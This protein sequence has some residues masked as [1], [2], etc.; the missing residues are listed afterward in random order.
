M[1]KLKII[2]VIFLLF[3]YIFVSLNIVLASDSEL[4]YSKT[5]RGNIIERFKKEQYKNIF[6]NDNIILNE[7]LNFFDTQ[8]RINIYENIRTQNNEKKEEL[9][10]KKNVLENRVLNLENTI[11]LIDE[12]IINIQ[13]EILNLS[14][15]IVAT[16]DKIEVTKSEIEKIS[17]EIYESKKV[18][19]EYI[20][21]IYKKQNLISI[22]DEID[23]LK[24]ILL[25]TD[26][27][28]DI[29]N[30]IHFS[31]I[32]ESTWQILLEKYKKLV[33]ELFIKKFDLEN[34]YIELKE[35]KKQ[36]F[37]KKKLQIEKK[38]FRKKIL[39][40]TKWRQELFE[41]FINNKINLDK[42]IKVKILQN[43][44]KLIKQKTELLTKYNC[45]YIDTNTISTAFENIEIDEE[46]FSWKTNN[47][48]CLLLNKILSLEAQLK[49]LKNSSNPLLWPVDTKNWISAYY[50]DPSY[51]DEIW[52]S[53][54]GI[55]IIVPQWTDIK[56]PADWYITYLKEPKDDWYAYV[57][58]K[59]TSWF[60]TVYW[61]VS[62]VL[63]KKYDIIKAWQVFARSWWE[64]GTN[65]A[66]IMTTWPH[67]H[68]EVWKDKKSSDPLE[69]LDLTKIPF[70]KLPNVVSYLNKYNRD[71]EEKYGYE[72]WWD[73]N[74]INMI[75]KVEWFRENAYL[76]S[77]W[78]RTIGYWFTYLNWEPVKEWDFITREEA[79]NELIKKINHYSNFKNFIKVPLTKEQEIA[80][81]SF[82]YNLWRNIW[83]KPTEDGWAMPIID[84][85]NV[86][87]LIWAA[88]YLKEFD[89][90][91]WKN[92][93]WLYN[94]RIKEANLLL[95]WTNIDSTDLDSIYSISS[96]QDNIQ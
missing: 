1:Q 61:H 19:L 74:I 96:N 53:H 88:K 10:I 6:E 89:S 37:L 60:I 57:V 95:K 73:L 65:W 54:E 52:S 31:I 12:D 23:S 81:T 87:D 58:L 21:H 91:W 11:K 41:Q 16:Q 72:Y 64:F 32:L 42:K 29:L 18:L 20:A 34:E 40:F 85:I 43:K 75:K 70:D 50:M 86:W 46:S 76:D 68:F 33:K 26:N 69:Y 48:N 7:D 25:N 5:I 47:D 27:L 78:I 63:F 90:A 79:D 83:T 38:E 80:L 84:M 28:S 13:E 44:I 77:A 59:H 14:R 94:R 36:E 71:Y 3:N 49:P 22:W 17:K 8:N 24:I 45:K 30:D 2:F 51:T 55:D 62:E 9:T 82:E 35:M 15:K 92:L 93:R 39:D 67:L 4:L 66:W 56:A